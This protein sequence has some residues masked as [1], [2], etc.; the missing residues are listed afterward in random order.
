M[1]FQFRSHRIRAGI[2]LELSSL[3]PEPWRSFL[4]DADPV[5]SKISTSLNDRD[6]IPSKEE[7]FSALLLNPES[8][9]VLIVGQD[10]YPNSEHAMGLAFSVR[11]EVRPLP[12]S[13]R[14]IFAELSAD[15]GIHNRSGDLT[16]WMNQGVLLLNRVMTTEQHESL[17]HVNIGWE[18]FTKTVIETIR[19]LNPVVVLWGRKAQELRGLFPEE[20]IISSAHPSP[21][22]AYKGFFG[23]KPFSKINALLKDDGSTEIDWR[24]DVREKSQ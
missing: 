23:S 5:L 17:S 3:L 18:E 14:N 15:L 9:K 19:E 24:T 20:R 13:L 21:L 6:F 8:V 7:I 10:P 2:L 22:S 1:E 12:A 16:P 11:H 4:P